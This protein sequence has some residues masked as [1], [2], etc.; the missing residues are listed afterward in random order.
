MDP[1]EVT[2]LVLAYLDRNGFASASAAFRRD[3][4]R[5]L[6]R[7]APHVGRVKDLEAIIHGYVLSH[8]ALSGPIAALGATVDRHPVTAALGV[9]AALFSLRVMSLRRRRARASVDD[10][11]PVPSHLQSPTP[12]P[13]EIELNG[14][15]ATGKDDEPEPSWL[16]EASAQVGLR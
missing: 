3:A 15:P 1:S 13:C 10:D 12:P 8:N 7:V 6:A 2:V 11:A 14:S 9:V 5:E 16:A 4:A